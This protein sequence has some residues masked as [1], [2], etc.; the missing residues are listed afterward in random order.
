MLAS[1]EQLRALVAKTLTL[2]SSLDPLVPGGLREEAGLIEVGIT[3]VPRATPLGWKSSVTS[4]VG[5]CPVTVKVDRQHLKLVQPSP[6]AFLAYATELQRRRDVAL[7]AASRAVPCT[8]RRVS[9]TLLCP[10]GRND[11]WTLSVECEQST[12]EVE[13]EEQPEVRVRTR[14]D[15]ATRAW[16]D[17]AETRLEALNRTFG[18]PARTRTEAKWVNASF[19]PVSSLRLVF[20]RGQARFELFLTQPL[21]AIPPG[22]SSKRWEVLKAPPGEHALR[23]S[24]AT[25]MAWL[26]S[27]GASPKEWEQFVA[28]ARSLVDGLLSPEH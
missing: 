3:F 2:P 12:F 10:S 20:T 15:S 18:A 4:V 25:A 13:V 14:A 24:T 17:L 22:D 7:E 26:R 9:A 1:D 6:A 21:E 23:R 8:P 19:R 11:F 28:A 5:F 27:T 16:L